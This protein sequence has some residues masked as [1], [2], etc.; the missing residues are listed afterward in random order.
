MASLAGREIYKIVQDDFVSKILQSCFPNIHIVNGECYLKQD[1]KLINITQRSDICNVV[2]LIKTLQEDETFIIY[3][4]N[5]L[6]EQLGNVYDTVVKSYMFYKMKKMEKQLEELINKKE[7]KTVPESL[8]TNT[9]NITV[10]NI[11]FYKSV[12]E[13]IVHDNQYLDIHLIDLK[14]KAVHAYW[15]TRYCGSSPLISTIDRYKEVILEDKTMTFYV[16]FENKDVVI[17]IDGIK[18]PDFIKSWLICELLI[19]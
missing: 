4:Q 8:F 2:K 14:N 12:C 10:P 17:F 7:V 5:G 15:R 6:R 16:L 19:I 11:E 3:D 1:Q 9:P 18:E 13:K